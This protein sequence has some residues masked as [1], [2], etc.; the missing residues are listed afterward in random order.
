MTTDTMAASGSQRG[1]ALLVTLIFLALFASLAVAIATSADMNMTLTRNRLCAQQAGAMAETGLQ[2]VQ[3]S[4]GGIQIN[5]AQNASDL[6]EAIAQ[7]LIAAWATS[8]MLDANNI[9]WNANA[10]SVPTITVATAAGEAG[11]IDLVLMAS[12]GAADDTT[13]TVRSTGRHR[14]ASRT[15]T[16]NMTVQRGSA[17]VLAYGIASK[18]QIQMT[19]NASISGANDPEEGSI[20][21]ATYST[22]RAIALTGNCS[23]SGDAGV[24][25]P[26]GYIQKTGNI[27]IGGSELIGLQE[28]EW[29]E[30]DPSVF[31]PYAVNTRSTGSSGNTTLTNIIIPPN[32]NPTFAGNTTIY[33]VVYVQSPNV[34]KFTGNTTLVGCII[35]EPPAVD[36]LTANAIQFT[37][38]MSTSGVENLPADA[39]YDGLRELTGSF[40][41]APGYGIKFT[42][43]FGTVNGCMVASSFQFTGNAGGRIAGGIVNLRDSQFSMTGNAHLVID[44]QNAAEHPA[45]LGGGYRLV[46]VSGSYSE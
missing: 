41:L 24:C 35:C 1:M 28:P 14:N 43:N 5:S 27:S 21:S 19:G 39:Q 44:K 6:H 2:L 30:V 33:G 36:N 8:G 4:L 29:P 22:A 16:Y 11:S 38:N 17:G 42:G 9:G 45:G 20:L 46:C 12:G 25:N 37:G 13:I 31:R 3:R 10:V 40:L 32:S 26:D 34:V 7:Q 15:I 18:S 23:V